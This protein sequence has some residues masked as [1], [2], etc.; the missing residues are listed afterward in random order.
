MA[1]IVVGNASALG[2][3]VR[4][5]RLL[6]GVSQTE[7]AADAK[8]G[9]QWLVALEAGS[10]PSAPFDMVMRV[11]QVLELEVALDPSTPR[12][13]GLQGQPFVPKASE[14]LSRYEK[15]TTR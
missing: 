8:V 3:A 12:R 10:K 6:A 11:L 13:S 1:T 15:G 7:L 2:A 4:E 5:A 9:R 14:V